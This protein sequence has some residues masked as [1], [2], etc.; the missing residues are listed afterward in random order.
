MSQN[1]V[2]YKD[3][4]RTN[5]RRVWFTGA[6]SL[7]L[8]MGLCYEMD[9][10]SVETGETATDAFVGR[11]AYVAL[12][13]NTNNLWFA[14][15]TAKDY[16][17]KTGGQ[18]VEIYEPGSVCEVAA[19]VNLVLGNV[20]TCSAGQGANGLFDKTGC[21]PG[22]GSALVLQTNAAVVKESH[23][24][25]A[26]TVAL[27]STGKIL[28]DTAATFVVNGV[29]AGDVVVITCGENDS[30][31][32]VTPGRYTVASVTSATALVLS[33]AASNGGTM[34][35]SYYVVDAAYP[36]VLVQLQDGEG[37]GLQ[38]TVRPPK[39]GH[40]TAD[41]FV[42]MKGGVTTL[43]GTQTL[44]TSAARET[45]PD[46]IYM[47]QRKRVECIST[48]TTYD[49]VFGVTNGSFLNAMTSITALHNDT[50]GSIAL[51][52]ADEYAQVEWCGSWKIE[53]CSGATLGA[54]S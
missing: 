41:T 42:A 11:G 9:Y 4:A 45:L 39:V 6:V 40:A 28:T 18:F 29:A 19:G 51:D 44:T 14:G 46:G 7:P 1:I 16:K 24:A 54:S 20:V 26:S 30:T 2:T 10:A 13:D 48:I 37:S 33:T 12:P 32:A 27:D 22:R 47:G 15:V 8:G 52:A 50:L 17:A 31:N 53:D 25:G 21:F 36:K 34:E 49:I 43:A 35:V 3:Q 23:L 5:P 38:E